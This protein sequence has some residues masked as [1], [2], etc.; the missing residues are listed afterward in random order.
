MQCNFISTSSA[1]HHNGAFS[2][3]VC[4]NALLYMLQNQPSTQVASNKR[5]ITFALGASMHKP[6]QKSKGDLK[7]C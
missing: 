7:S 5:C 1:E 4:L 2:C 6:Q 3:V